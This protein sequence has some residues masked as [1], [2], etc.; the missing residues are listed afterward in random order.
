[1]DIIHRNNNYFV[2]KFQPLV[3]EYPQ[4]EFI[5]SIGLGM[6]ILVLT[7]FINNIDR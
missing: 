7:L 2:P 4:S 5:N 3:S 1:M 6:T